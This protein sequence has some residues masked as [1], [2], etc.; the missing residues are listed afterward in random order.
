M[1]KRLS[2]TKSEVRLIDCLLDRTVVGGVVGFTRQGF[3]IRK[4]ELHPVTESL[5]GKSVVITGATSGIG[6]AA[7]MMIAA[8]GPRVVLIG[9]NSEKLEHTKTFLMDRTGNPDIVSIQ[10]DLSLMADIKRVAE[11]MKRD[12]IRVDALI[13]N[14]GGLFNARLETVEGIEQTLATDLAGPFLLTNLLIPLLK[15]SASARIINVSSGG[16]YT[17]KIDVEDLCFKR[18]PYNGSKAY[19]RAKRGIVI[20]SE[21][22]AHYLQNDG[23]VVN[24][25]HPGWVNTPGLVESLPR[26][27][28]MVRPFLRTPQQGADTIVWLAVSSE[29]GE[30]SGKFWLDRRPHITHVFPFT[31]ES[32]DDRYLLWNRLCEITGYRGHEH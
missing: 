26:F 20:L 4:R 22:W 25:M 18:E 7:A 3:E 27:H 21:M 6:E 11:H 12:L 31:R 5:Y 1:G 9:R 29:A 19:A 13:N 23:I 24:S 16:M 28:S 10:G 30:V 8:L 32:D 14:A 15:S 17:Q 2:T